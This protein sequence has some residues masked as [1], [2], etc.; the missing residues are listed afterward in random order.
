MASSRKFKVVGF[1]GTQ[2][3]SEEFAV[4]ELFRTQETE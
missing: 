2:I 1:E 3:V 4:I